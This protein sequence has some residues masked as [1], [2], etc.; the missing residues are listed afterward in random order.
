MRTHFPTSIILFFL[1]AAL[2]L[3]AQSREIAPDISP[4]LN[5][6]RQAWHDG[7]ALAARIV[8]ASRAGG[9]DIG[10]LLDQRD[11]AFERASDL[12]RKA[13][14]KDK[15][16]PQALYDFGR[17][18]IAQGD[19]HIARRYLE[20]AWL[21]DFETPAP[22]SGAANQKI[23]RPRFN[24]DQC[25]A[26]A[27]KTF[28]AAEQADLLR[29]LGGVT[30]RAG[31][32]ANAL[33]CYRAACKRNSSDPRNRLSLA[34]ALYAGGNAAETETLLKP[35]D[36]NQSSQAVAPS[37]P[38]FPADRPNI[39]ALGL[40]T[41]GLSKE[42]LG[43][44]EETLRLY[45]LAD[46][47]AH[48]APENREVAENARLASIRV[49]DRIDEW[50]ERDREYQRQIVAVRKYNESLE[51]LNK[52][53]PELRRSLPKPEPQDERKAMRDALGLFDSAMNNEKQ[54][55]RD[56]VLVAEMGKLWINAIKAAELEK[57]PEY[58][59]FQSAETMFQLSA[60]KYARHARTHYELAL[61]EL[62]LHRYSSARTL[63]DAAA[64]YNP[65]DIATLNVRGGVLLEL[66]QWEAAVADFSRLLT[67]DGENGSAQFGLARAL[68]ALKS[69][70]RVCEA[71]LEAFGRASRLGLRDERMDVARALRAKDGQI[72][73]GLI[74]SDGKDYIVKE[75]YAA[76]FRIEKDQVA[77]VIEGPGLREQVAKVLD[78]YRHGISPPEVKRVFGRKRGMEDDTPRSLR[79]D[80]T[81]FSQ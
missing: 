14:D 4:E 72:Y 67:L 3:S 29:A 65:N 8:D 28:T 78:D 60:M 61:A 52:D 74:I 53:L 26:R 54:A 73:N 37:A 62:L 7:D 57:L 13:L 71:A 25:G 51:L 20:N 59:L 75:E 12:F 50:N 80:Q 66:G 39:L 76:P 30:E 58:A 32:Y 68:A 69:N 16:H 1:N 22:E 77:E 46:E 48:K 55:L 27:G 19:F 17:Y 15:S 40:Y 47:L 5:A 56:P 42:Q 33:A 9:G 23:A 2:C 24:V 38:D 35:W 49:E 63:L 6:A 11:A 43:Y 34:V 44:Q 10:A 64:L 18:W 21:S 81:I 79:P 70:E 41:L 31:E 45:R 36:E